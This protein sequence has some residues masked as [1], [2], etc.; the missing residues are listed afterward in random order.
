MAQFRPGHAFAVDD[1][2]VGGDE[3][4]N[5][6]VRADANQ[7]GVVKGNGDVVKADDIVVVASDVDAI[8]RQFERPTRHR[9]R[10]KMKLAYG[11]RRGVNHFGHPFPQGSLP[12]PPGICKPRAAQSKKFQS[13]APAAQTNVTLPQ[14]FGRIA[15]PNDGK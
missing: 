8:L 10:D 2:P 11:A 9:T 15:E 7:D 3:V 13:C 1:R 14:P 12:R 6:V 5:L 4:A